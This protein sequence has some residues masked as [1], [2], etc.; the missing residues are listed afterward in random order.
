MMHALR[1][2]IWNIVMIGALFLL[3]AYTTWL[4]K[5]TQEPTL[6]T[7]NDDRLPDFIAHDVVATETNEQ[8]LLHNQFITPKIVHYTKNDTAFY[9]KP[10]IISYP[11][12]EKKPWDITAD[13]GQSVHGTKE[14]IL[15]GNVNIHE[16]ES[17]LNND[18][19]MTTSRLV[20]YP[21]KNYA[22]T[23][24][25][26]TFT[27]PGLVVN[28]VGMKIY[29]KEKRVQLLNQARGEYDATKAK[30]NVHQ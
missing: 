15:W 10:H 7:A 16:P 5:K 14:L 1:V 28:S 17:A 11:N 25:P 3:V 29:F 8:G 13:H 27:E 23:D 18:I 4:L 9:D 6:I 2:N 30:N 26:V 12:N 19:R 20:V 22:E 24:Q 21:E